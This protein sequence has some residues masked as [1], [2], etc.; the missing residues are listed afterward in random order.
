[1][2]HT[3]ADLVSGVR[4]LKNIDWLLSNIK[5]SPVGKKKLYNVISFVVKFVGPIIC[6]DS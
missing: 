3:F 5:L 4:A 6:A 1:M 2:F